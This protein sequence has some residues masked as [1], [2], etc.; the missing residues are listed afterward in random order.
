MLLTADCKS[1][2]FEECTPSDQRNSI[3]T[4]PASDDVPKNIVVRPKEV[5][6]KKKRL[7]G[8]KGQRRPQKAILPLR[9]LERRHYNSISTEP[10]LN[11]K[12]KKGIKEGARGLKFIAKSKSSP[13]KSS[14][15]DRRR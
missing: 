15:R 6:V 5:G 3:L 10:L 1:S 7:A 11:P 13:C 14:Q 9:D 8:G 2:P 12:T 4:N